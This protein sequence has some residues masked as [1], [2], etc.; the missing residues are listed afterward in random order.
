[1]RHALLRDTTRPN[2]NQSYLVLLG[3]A[4]HGMTTFICSCK[5][6]FIYGSV[7]WWSSQQELTILQDLL[8]QLSLQS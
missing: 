7:V 1:L 4:Q 2:Q 8:S 5:Q 6:A 3:V